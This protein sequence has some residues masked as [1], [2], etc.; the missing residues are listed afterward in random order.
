MVVM[1]NKLKVNEVVRE[2]LDKKN[3]VTLKDPNPAL[4]PEE[5]KNIYANE[6]PHLVNARVDGPKV[7]KTKLKYTFV[8][9]VGTKG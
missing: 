1:A 8:T 5:V 9:N 7:L 6:Y 3:N 4:T 2:F